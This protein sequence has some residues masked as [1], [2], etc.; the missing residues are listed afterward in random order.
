MEPDVTALI[1]QHAERVKKAARLELEAIV[2]EAMQ[3][4]DAAPKAPEDSRDG[5][6]MMHDKVFEKRESLLTVMVRTGC[7]SWRGH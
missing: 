2:A 4:R 7:P 5:R 1:E 3:N 6:R